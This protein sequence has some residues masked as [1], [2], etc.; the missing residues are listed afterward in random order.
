ME[1]LDDNYLFDRSDQTRRNPHFIIPTNN[2]NPGQR[3][4]L[5]LKGCKLLCNNLEIKNNTIIIFYDNSI[6]ING[7]KEEH[8]GIIPFRKINFDNLDLILNLIQFKIII[9]NKNHIL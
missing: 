5:L 9:Q 3:L 1:S 4:K 6:E 7:E 2:I 8:D